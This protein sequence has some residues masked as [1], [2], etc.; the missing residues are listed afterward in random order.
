LSKAR[1]VT[2]TLLLLALC[3]HGCLCDRLIAGNSNDSGIDLDVRDAGGLPDAGDAG[4]AD[5]GRSDSGVAD[6]GIAD[7]GLDCS[8]TCELDAQIFCTNQVF[9]GSCRICEP[10]VDGGPWI[11]EPPGT[12]C[13]DVPDVSP[14]PNAIGACTALSPEGEDCSCS[15]N[16]SVCISATGCCWGSCVD[17]G[18]YAFCKGTRGPCAVPGQCLSHVCC[19]AGGGAGSC[20]DEN[21]TCAGP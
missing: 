11:W 14:T 6:S 21:G 7:A 4:P 10:G 3:V 16:G 5:A 8:R 18:Q 20:A 19:N 9:A 2:P 17:A 13:M 1:Y 15:V 12:A